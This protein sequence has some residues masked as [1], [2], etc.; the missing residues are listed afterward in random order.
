[1]QNEQWSPAILDFLA[2]MDVGKTAGPPVAVAGEEEAGSEASEWENREYEEHLAQS[3]EG[4]A[5]LGEEE[6]SICFP[7][8][9]GGFT[10]FPFVN[11][12]AGSGLWVAAL[13]CRLMYISQS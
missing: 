13:P 12:K 7:F 9:G 6:R 5:N 3:T 8:S 11:H 1:L 4:E 10:Y 2:T